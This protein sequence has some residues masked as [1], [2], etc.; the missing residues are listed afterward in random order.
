MWPFSKKGKCTSWSG[1]HTFST[2]ET[3]DSSLVVRQLDNEE[4]QKGRYL[5][6]E[7][8]CEVCGLK[9]LNIQKSTI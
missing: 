7:R 5:I 2:W 6:Q 1:M 8:R 9:E 4:A 3:I